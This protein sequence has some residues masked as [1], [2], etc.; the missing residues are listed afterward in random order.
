MKK[1]YHLH[2]TS[3]D[4]CIGGLGQTRPLGTFPSVPPSLQELLSNSPGDFLNCLIVSP[5]ITDLLIDDA[6]PEDWR[7]FD[8][9]SLLH[10]MLGK[11]ALIP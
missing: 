1:R 5:F 6:P 3:T 11:E 4:Q 9:S 7:I 2:M 8:Q 10:P